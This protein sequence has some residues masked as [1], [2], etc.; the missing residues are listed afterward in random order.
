M[1]Y[2]KADVQFAANDFLTSSTLRNII[3]KLQ[4]NNDYIFK[5]SIISN[6]LLPATLDCQI[7]ATY[8]TSTYSFIGESKREYEEVT[9][10]NIEDIKAGYVL[11]EIEGLDNEGE[12]PLEIGDT[13]KPAYTNYYKVPHVEATYKLNNGHLHQYNLS[14]QRNT[15]TALDPTFYTQID[16]LGNIIEP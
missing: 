11:N 2:N 10:D 15:Q 13:P 6:T 8:N 1:P 9:E 3:L 4:D 12:Y 14:Q 7:L 16:E 5:N